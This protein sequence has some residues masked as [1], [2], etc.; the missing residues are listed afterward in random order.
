[1]IAGSF[2]DEN[3]VYH[4]YIRAANGTITTFDVPGSGCPGNPPPSASKGA[5]PSGGSGFG[6]GTEA[7]S[8]DDAGDVAGNYTDPNCVR[9][10]FVRTANGVITPFDAPGAGTGAGMIQGTGG[11]SINAS[12]VVA[13]TYADA[14]AVVHGFLRATNGTIASLDAPGA[15][16]GMFQGTV[17][18]G[19]NTAGE[20]TGTYL[21]ASSV[22]HGYVLTPSTVGYGAVYKLTHRGS[23]WTINPVYTFSNASN[24]A[25]PEAGVIVGP[26][27][28]LYGTTIYGGTSGSGTVFNL[29]PSATACVA[30]LCP[31][32]ETVLYS[33]L[34]GGDGAYP[35]YGNLIFQAGDIYGSTAGGG[36]SGLGTVYELMPSGD[37]WTE[38]VLHSFSGS[39][40]ATPFSGVLF[41]SS[42]N[43]YGTTTAGGTGNAGT[44]FKMT[45]SSGSGWTES[46][47]YS[48]LNGNDGGY[49]TAGLTLGSSGV[50]YGATSNGGSGGGGTV[51]KLTPSGG[52]W[53]YS[54]IYSFAGGADCGPWGALAPDMAGNLY[55]TTLCD[56]ANNFGSIFKLTQSGS[57]WTYSSI[58]AFTGG[59][60]GAFPYGNAVFDS[61]GNLY[62][63]AS[64][65]GAD[66][67]GVAWEITP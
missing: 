59:T 27:G 4:G 50:L 19:I 43:L 7:I 61:S 18:F 30:V 32:Q 8:I 54:L 13:G 26:N 60:G 23:G 15:G 65:G 20:I 53:T 29:R 41:D 63:T 57:G 25:N 67:Y 56:G 52:S 39:D 42:G 22:G 14:N 6:S 24:G 34:N 38:S 16:T 47:L 31:W 28:S 9:H 35:G 51:F 45:Y 12:A 3:Y 40:G 1:M 55:G 66:G 5:A 46:V 10:G 11:F 49:P 21:D 37:G 44:V 17:G 36:N 64:A 2:Q 58:H 62:G 48:F 33:F